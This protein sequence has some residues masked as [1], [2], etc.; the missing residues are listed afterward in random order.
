MKKTI[1]RT[2]SDGYAEHLQ[3]LRETKVLFFIPKKKWCYV[4]W[5]YYDRIRGRS[6]D[7]SGYDTLVCSYNNNLKNFPQKWP[8]IN[9]YFEWARK[10]QKRLEDDADRIT[11]EI[12]KRKGSV[13]YL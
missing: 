13:E 6:L 9:E 11:N 8:D 1:Y 7:F 4:W 2:I 12:N 5:P 10:E 3:Y